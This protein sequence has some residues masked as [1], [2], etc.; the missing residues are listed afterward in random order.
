MY[1]EKPIK[2]YVDELASSSPTPGGGGTGALVAALGIALGDMVG[3]LTVGKKKYE[4]VEDEIKALME[5]A[6]KLK[7]E[8][9]RLVDADAEAFEPLSKAYGIPKDDP[10]RDEIMEKALRDAA[11]VPLEILRNCKKALG[12]IEAFAEKG[13]KLAISDAGCGASL[14]GAALESAALNVF[15]NTKYMKDRGYADSINAEVD[16]TLQEYR[17]KSR[18]IYEFVASNLK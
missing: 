10:N 2:T 13:S 9:L 6:Q 11:A 1:I 15:I 12:L 5:E 7:L 14:C 4:A 18:Q 8:F 17:K 16:E 3:E